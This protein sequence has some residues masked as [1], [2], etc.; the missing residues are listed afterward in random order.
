MLVH[1]HVPRM[2]IRVVNAIGEDLGKERVEE[3]LGELRTTYAAGIDGRLIGHRRP[4]HLIHD[5]HAPR[6]HVAVDLGDVDTL[7]AN[8]GPSHGGVVRGL[9]S[10][11]Q[12]LRDARDQ[13]TRQSHDTDAAR[14]R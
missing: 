14:C 2:R 4:H 5:Q 8:P 7:I 1:E 9:A 11:V 13:L 12:L 10:E 3:I 6:R